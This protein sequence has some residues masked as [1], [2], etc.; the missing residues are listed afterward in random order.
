[1]VTRSK[2]E[3]NVAQPDVAKCPGYAIDHVVPTRTPFC[4]PHKK[5]TSPANCAQAMWPERAFRRST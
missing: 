4:R 2:L 1:M 5:G 3:W